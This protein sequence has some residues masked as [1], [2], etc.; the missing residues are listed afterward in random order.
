MPVFTCYYQARN[1]HICFLFQPALSQGAITFVFLFF[2]LFLF[3]SFF[4]QKASEGHDERNAKREASI[5]KSQ[6]Q[7]SRTN[8]HTL[9]QSTLF[10]HHFGLLELFVT[11]T[12]IINTIQRKTYV[13]QTCTR[14]LPTG[15]LCLACND[16][17]VRNG[18]MFDEPSGQSNILH[19]SLL[20]IL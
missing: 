19:H 14:P 1:V 2:S 18:C 20:Q 10:T 8:S 3:L 11:F 5:S 15:L 6:A 16:W 12:A 13:V 9:E 17:W 7:P 4:S